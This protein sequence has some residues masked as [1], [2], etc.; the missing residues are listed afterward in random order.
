MSIPLFISRFLPQSMRQTIH[1]MLL[2]YWWIGVCVL[3]LS[4]WAGAEMLEVIGKWPACRLCH[5]ERLIFLVMGV[6]SGLR[7]GAKKWQSTVG[8]TMTTVLTWSVIGTCMIGFL[9]SIYHTA[10]Q[11]H[12]IALPSFCEIPKAGTFEQ[13]M[14][15]PSA[16]C[17]QWTL[18]FLF[19]PMPV[20][21]IFLFENIAF[22]S[23]YFSRV[24]TPPS[25]H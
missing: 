7:I 4:A 15:L 19:I 2:S 8:S 24:K 1:Q 13:F 9:I 5:V 10:I 3:G 12:W 21:L 14:A 25:P 17:D 11:F 6:L 18:T 16:T 22:Y 20:Y 23:W